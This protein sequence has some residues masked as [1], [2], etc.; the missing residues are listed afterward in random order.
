[1][2]SLVDGVIAWRQVKPLFDAS[3]RPDLPG[4]LALVRRGQGTDSVSTSNNEFRVIL[5]A[6][7]LTYRH[8]G[9][10][11]DVLSQCDLEIRE[12]DRVLLQGPSG[13]GK[14]TLAGL[15]A[16][17]RR[18]NSG[19]LLVH[20]FDYASLGERGWK[21]LVALVPQFHENH[22]LADTFLFNLLMGRR[23]PPEPEDIAAAKA[24]CNDLGLGPLIR[25]M[26]AGLNQL[27]GNTG[28]QL[29][30]GER[31]RLFVA[32]ALLQD[33]DLVIFDE[34]FG[35]LDPVT[36]RECLR[37]VLKRSQATLLIAHP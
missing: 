36:L 7:N 16:G 27:V 19:V 15:L 21:R 11:S 30:H 9:R 10:T 31:S 8:V 3:A 18:P 33:P 32:R 20:G 13:A 26:P 1:M 4:M 14:S 5:D 22:V 6:R 28:W 25:R 24:V 23:W 29:S 12:H 35:A 37:C 2:V 17:L 34:S